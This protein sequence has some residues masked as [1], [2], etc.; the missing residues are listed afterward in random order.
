MKRK[1]SPTIRLSSTFNHL[2]ARAEEFDI[3]R[4][5]PFRNIRPLCRAVAGNIHFM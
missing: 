3:A 2:P 1:G 4:G 5:R